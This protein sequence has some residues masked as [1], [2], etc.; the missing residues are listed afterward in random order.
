MRLRA[1]V[2][3]VAGVASLLLAA[4][5]GGAV[6]PYGANDAGGFRNVLPPGQAGTD[7]ALQLGLFLSTGTRPAHWD[8]QQRLYTGLVQASPGLTHGQIANYFK[9]ATFGVRSG[10]VEST[11]SPR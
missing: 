10:D 5:A 2:A 3:T 7:N 11:V 9:D 8:D 4:P 1:T 6:A